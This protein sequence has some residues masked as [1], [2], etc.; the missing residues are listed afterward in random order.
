MVYEYLHNLIFKKFYGIMKYI[1][2]VLAILYGT[3]SESRAQKTPASDSVLANA[4][5]SNCV[6]YALSHYPL[7]QQSI[8]DEDITESQIKN[9]LA[10]WYPQIGLNYNYQINFQLPS[11]YFGGGYVKTGTY[12]TSMLGLGATQNI[13]NR[14]VLLASRTA[15]DIRKQVKQYTSANKI[16]VVVN[17]SKAFYEVLVTQKQ[18]DVLNEDIVRLERS[19]KDAY[20]QYKG[21][22][23]DKT[24]YKRATIALN[25][26]KAQKKST[27]DLLKAKYANLKL[28]MGY[29]KNNDMTL[30]Y[31]SAKM[32]KDVYL[33]TAQT[34]NYENRIEYQTLQTQKSL[35]Q[36][37]LKYAKWSYL[38]TLSAFGNYNMSFL[39]NDFGKLYSQSFNYSLAGL[40]LSFP[41]FQGGKRVQQV[42]QA[43]LSLSR[44][45]W[46][47]V[48]LKNNVNTQYVAALSNYKSNLNDY[49]VLKDNLELARDVYNTIQ[50]QYRSGIKTYLDVITAE[51]DLRTAEVNYTNILYQVLSSKLDVQKALGNIQF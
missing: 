21:G 30:E 18:I 45:D 42:K 22:V 6:Q 4:T 43:Q 46:D 17:V 44:L 20:N 39:N 14:D 10:D 1:F 27:E 3:V 50:L 19:L 9:K 41:I 7:V 24:D 29:T 34:V 40:Q 49:N 8:L 33:D 37:N 36:A 2:C 11:S 13:F 48:S 15:Q 38:P 32:E 47:I 12:N 51:T 31:D 35:Q 23:V 25:N 26:S 16:D 28:Q 5:L